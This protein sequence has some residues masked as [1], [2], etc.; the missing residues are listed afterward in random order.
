MIRDN[1]P[2]ESVVIAQQKLGE[3]REPVRVP[4]TFRKG[5]PAEHY[6]AI[7]RNLRLLNRESDAPRCVGV[8]RVPGGSAQS[9]V[10]TNLAVRLAQ[11]TDDRVLLVAA[12]AHNPTIYSTFAQKRQRVTSLYDILRD[13]GTLS[14]AVLTGAGDNLFI[15]AVRPQ[16]T[17]TQEDSRL[18]RFANLLE[19]MKQNYEYVIFDLPDASDMTPCFDF[20]VELDGVVLEVE[21]SRVRHASAR[22]VERQLRHVEATVLGSILTQ[23]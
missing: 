19:D 18:I 17:A 21:A 12:N 16:R 6:A 4:N 9:V 5:T 3:S 15:L 10:A 20:A 8:T 14:D 7:I 22:W 1:P 13:E 11:L 23:F 2:T